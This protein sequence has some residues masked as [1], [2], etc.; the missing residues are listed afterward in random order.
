MKR[1]ASQSSSSGG[2]GSLP[3][4]AKSSCGAARPGPEGQ[5]PDA[6]DHDAGGEWVGA[7]RQPARQPESV[8]RLIRGERRQAGRRIARHDLL[9][10]VIRAALEAMG[11]TRA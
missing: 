11:P 4:L 10:R 2:E 3:W 9:W 5:A 8:A 7:I 6:V 1:P